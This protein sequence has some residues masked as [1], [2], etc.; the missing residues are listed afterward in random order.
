MYLKRVR[1]YSEGS[2]LN[3]TDD[4]NIVI[5]VNFVPGTQEE[6]K[7]IYKFIDKNGVAF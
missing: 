6:T 5:D 1:D 2:T 4:E 3:N 7:C